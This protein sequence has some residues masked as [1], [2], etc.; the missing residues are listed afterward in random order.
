M[1]GLL[2]LSYTKPLA[3]N[4]LRSMRLAISRTYRSC[5]ELFRFVW[6]VHEAA[7]WQDSTL[8]NQCGAGSDLDEMIH[9]WFEPVTTSGAV[10]GFLLRTES[11][12]F[13]DFA[14]HQA[15]D[16]QV[17]VNTPR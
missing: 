6:G 11:T 10:P 5:V 8:R 13:N 2:V 17:C 15:A 7:E 9:P 16:K 3:T 12:D 1:V 4:E 14:S